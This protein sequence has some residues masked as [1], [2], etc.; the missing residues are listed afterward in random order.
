MRQAASRAE[1]APAAAPP[2]PAVADC[3]HANAIPRSRPAQASAWAARPARR[4]IDFERFKVGR[5]LATIVWL[6]PQCSAISPS[7]NPL[8]IAAPGV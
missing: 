5:C 7:F 4:A 1:G 3:P 8:A 2:M 6:T